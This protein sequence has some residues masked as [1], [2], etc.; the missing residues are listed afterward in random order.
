MRLGTYPRRAASETLREL[1]AAT[2]NVVERVSDVLVDSHASV[3]EW[4][5]LGGHTDVSLAHVEDWELV[6][7]ARVNIWLKGP[8][9]TTRAAVASIRSSLTRPVVTLRAGASLDFLRRSSSIGTLILEDASALRLDDQRRLLAWLD[10][11]AGTRVISS[12]TS[13]IPPLIKAGVYL[14]SL[15]YRLNTVYVEL[16]SDDRRSRRVTVP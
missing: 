14:D 8:Q 6:S 16:T 4:L 3:R 10:A 11:A 1:A 7:A 12:T 5:R 9:R 13:P 15:Y 2:G